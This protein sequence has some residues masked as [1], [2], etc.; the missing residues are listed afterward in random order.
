MN[1]ANVS[2]I[3]MEDADSDE[4][5]KFEGVDLVNSKPHGPKREELKFK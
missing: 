2:A 5:Y 3:S 1:T 4:F